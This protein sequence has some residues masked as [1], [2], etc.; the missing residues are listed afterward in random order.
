MGVATSKSVGVVDKN[1]R[2]RQ[3][4]RVLLHAHF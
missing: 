4:I 3:K 2:G 1:G